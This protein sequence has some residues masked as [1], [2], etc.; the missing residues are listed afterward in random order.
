MKTIQIVAALLAVNLLLTSCN[1][2]ELADELTELSTEKS[3]SGNVDTDSKP[4][5]DN[6]GTATPPP[7]SPEA[8]KP[9]EQAAPEVATLPSPPPATDKPA[10]SDTTVAIPMLNVPTFNYVEPPFNSQPLFSKTCL[11]EENPGKCSG[12]LL[13]KWLYKNLQYLP[14]DGLQ[15]EPSVEYISF[16]ID[17]Y[18]KVVD[19]NHAGTKGPSNQERAKAALEAVRKMPKWQPAMRNGKQVSYSVVLPVRFDMI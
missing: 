19:I 12:L 8:G 14:A 10:S 4:S 5:P 15:G 13:K 9:A 7:A 17:K 2:L 18:G 6:A 16:T 11:F 3:V 1:K